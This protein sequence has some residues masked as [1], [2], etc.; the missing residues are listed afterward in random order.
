MVKKV[1]QK[2][3]GKEIVLV[4]GFGATL[5]ASLFVLMILF[6]AIMLVLF[7]ALFL[8]CALVPVITFWAFRDAKKKLEK[9]K[10]LKSNR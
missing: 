7:W 1:T 9:E 4:K 8:I 2:I 3:H 6:F 10:C 5:V